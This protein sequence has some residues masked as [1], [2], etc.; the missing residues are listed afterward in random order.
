MSPG[1]LI[2]PAA[3]NYINP[4]IRKIYPAA[5][6]N[7]GSFFFW[8]PSHSLGQFVG[9]PASGTVVNNIARKPASEITG[10]ADLSLLDGKFMHSAAGATMVLERTPAGGVHALPSQVNA[11]DG[12]DYAMISPMEALQ[13]YLHAHLNDHW[14]FAAAFRLTRRQV[15]TAAPASPFHKAQSTAAYLFHTA[16]GAVMPAGGGAYLGSTSDPIDTT[17]TA[18]APKSFYRSVSTAAYTGVLAAMNTLGGFGE[19]VGHGTRGVHLVAGGAD[20]WSGANINKAPGVVLEMFYIEHLTTSGRSHA[21]ADAD[22]K[23][24]WAARRAVGGAWHG[25]TLPTEPATFP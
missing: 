21:A 1:I 7:A 17:Q 3:A 10:V 24:Y 15:A 20:A 19:G 6:M 2:R 8:D 12:L 18:V 25:D 13:T 22:C 11:T 14:F 16:N 4:L 5:F 9:I 23:A